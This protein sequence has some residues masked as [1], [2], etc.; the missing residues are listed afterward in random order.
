[1]P[2]CPVDKEIIKPQEVRTNW[3]A[4][5]VGEG[6][7]VTTR[8][9]WGNVQGPAL[10]PILRCCGSRQ[11]LLSVWSMCGVCWPH[12][13]TQGLTPSYASSSHTKL[14]GKVECPI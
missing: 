2:I 4:L 11:A 6:T 1:M 3:F 14:L 10:S 12:H 13:T 7:R 8:L 9:E 5:G